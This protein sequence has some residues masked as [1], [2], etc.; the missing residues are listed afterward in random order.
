MKTS[1]EEMRQVCEG[2]LREYEGCGFMEPAIK[3]AGGISAWQANDWLR[4]GRELLR[5]GDEPKDERY[6]VMLWFATEQQRLSGAVEFGHLSNIKSHS[7]NDWKASTWLLEMGNRGVYG[8]KITVSVK[9]EISKFLDRLEQKLPPE[10]YQDVLRAALAAGDEDTP[11][12][13]GGGNASG[14]ETD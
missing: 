6:A 9:Q 7:A 11:E 12:Q 8:Q 13:G 4:K 3:K 1:A 10:V 14:E 5:T 2:I